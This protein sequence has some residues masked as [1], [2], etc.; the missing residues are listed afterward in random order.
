MQNYVILVLQA[1]VFDTGAWRDHLKGA[2][3]VIS[4]LGAFGSNDFMQKVCLSFVWGWL[5]IARTQNSATTI[6]D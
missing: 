5:C 2:V 4:C 1:N 6:K 3:G